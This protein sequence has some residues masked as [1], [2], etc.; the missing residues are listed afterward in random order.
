LDKPLAR[1]TNVFL[2]RLFD[3]SPCG[4]FCGFTGGLGGL[5]GMG[6][7]GGRTGFFPSNSPLPVRFGSTS[8]F[9]FF[10]V[11]GEI[12]GLPVGI[13]GFFTGGVGDCLFGLSADSFKLEVE[14]RFE[15]G[16][17]L[18][19]LAS[20]IC[21]FDPRLSDTTRRRSFTGTFGDELPFGVFGDDF[22]GVE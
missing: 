5:A 21:S 13:F 9:A 11:W 18:R 6:G 19:R 20:A 22:R 1:D 15:L 16:K 17:V 2:A 10:S 3:F 8:G 14:E 4:L 12:E 7:L